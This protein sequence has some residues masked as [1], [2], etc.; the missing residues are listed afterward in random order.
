MFTIPNYLDVLVEK[1]PTIEVGCIGSSTV[2]SNIIYQ[3]GPALPSKEILDTDLLVILKDRI[4]KE[5]QAI[6]DARKAA[7]VQVGNNW[8]H[9]D[10]TS[11]IQFIGLLM[12]G[13]NMPP[14]IM[15]KTM[16]GSFIEMTPTL[17]QQIFGT[18]AN[19]DTA[20]FTVAEQHK[21]AMMASSTPETYNYTTGSPSWPLV[22]GE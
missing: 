4:W 10:D 9:S 21:A 12:Y 22:Y 8:F 13:A 15:W 5:I 6:R 7:G 1:Y 16:D 2:Y 18:I 17:A 19:K 3:A 14:G 11:R 20:I